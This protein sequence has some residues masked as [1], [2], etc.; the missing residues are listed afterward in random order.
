MSLLSI[1]QDAADEIGVPQPSQ[2]V[3]NKDKTTTALLRAYI[4]EGRD[5]LQEEIRSAQSVVGIPGENETRAGEV[6][7][8]LGGRSSRAAELDRRG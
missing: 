7:G 3:G 5:L 6:A 4:K 8:V 1:I 2:V